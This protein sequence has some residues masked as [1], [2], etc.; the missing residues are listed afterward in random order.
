[1]CRPHRRSGSPQEAPLRPPQIRQATAT[2]EHSKIACYLPPRKPSPQ[3]A[4]RDGCVHYLRVYVRSLLDSRMDSSLRTRTK[5]SLGT[6]KARASPGSVQASCAFRVLDDLNPSASS[7]K[8][9]EVR[10][11][12][13]RN[14]G[15]NDAPL[16]DRP[17]HHPL[18]RDRGRDAGVDDAPAD[19]PLLVGPCDGLVPQGHRIPFLLAYE[20][21]ALD[22]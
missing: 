5:K 20:D 13:E 14:L 21:P 4:K 6:R 2:L 12:I 1:M 9:L 19:V 16:L 15:R 17:V 11:R 22:V 8:F 7:R 10:Q 3:R 18:G